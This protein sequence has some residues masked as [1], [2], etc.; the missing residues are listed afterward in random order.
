REAAEKYIPEMRAKGAEL[1]VAISHGGI[2]GAPYSPKME[3]AG[4]YLAQ[5][6]GIDA[7]LLGHAHAVFPDAASKA[8]QFNLPGIDKARGSVWGVPTVMASLWGKHLGVIGLHLRHDGKRWVVDKDQ[9][10]A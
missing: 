2:D 1:V 3:N 4:Y 10:T 7:M 8:P 6:P 5:V 9:T